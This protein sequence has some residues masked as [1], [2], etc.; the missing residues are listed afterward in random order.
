MGLHCSEG[1]I[2]W[3]GEM[4][5][6]MG[7]IGLFSQSGQL[8]NMI[9]MMGA[10]QRLSFSKVVSFGNACDLKAHDFLN[11]L[12]S[13]PKT[14]II[15]SYIEGLKR[16]RAFFESA[17]KIAKE[18][19]IVI[20]K[21][22][23]TEGGARATQ[24]HTA[25]LAGSYQIW[26]SMCRQAGIISVNSMEELAYTVSALKRLALPKGTKV[27]VM[28]GA[29]GGSVIMTDLAEKNGLT[30]PHLSDNSIKRL[31]EFIPLNGSS[32]KNPLDILPHMR[33]TE[34]FQKVMEILRDDPNID[35]LLFSSNLGFIYREAGR[36]GV[37]YYLRMI[38]KCQEWLEKPMFLILETFNNVEM[39]T[40][41]QEGE[42][43]LVGRKMAVFP[44]F[45]IAAKVLT[46]LYQ[47]NNFL[48]R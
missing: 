6:R 37:N 35:A 1:G 32:V 47:Y 3:N 10:T 25:A 8:A 2:S 17:K 15:T 19:P 24:S 33:D 5:D 38:A 20:W 42:E 40:L 9:V 29:G 7:S 48:C 43:M 44:S 16:G 28:G 11:Y 14:Q 36:L 26:E 45:E 12:A 27:A 13:D 30:V 21:G 18:K 4:P 46:Y 34:T 31:E 23:Q 39:L 22:G 41:R